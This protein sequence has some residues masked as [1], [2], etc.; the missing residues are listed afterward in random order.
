MGETLNSPRRG[1]AQLH[2]MATTSQGT[3]GGSCQSA[4]DRFRL[5][6]AEWK[7]G[8]KDYQRSLGWDSLLPGLRVYHDLETHNIGSN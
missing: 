6:T 4:L 7:Y 3:I 5:A 1:E 8:L 2:E